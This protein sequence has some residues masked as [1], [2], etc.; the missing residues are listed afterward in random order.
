M[1]GKSTAKEVDL[2]PLQ[3]GAEMMMKA[4]GA[5]LKLALFEPER[6]VW[7]FP[8]I[9]KE[10]M[11]PITKEFVISVSKMIAGVGQD[12]SIPDQLGVTFQLNGP[13]LDLYSTDSKTISWI[14]LPN[15]KAYE[16]EHAVLPT[17]F[18]NQLVKLCKNGGH[19]IVQDDCAIVESPSGVRL[20]ARLVDVPRPVPF[21][22][23]ISRTIDKK[24]KS[25]AVPVPSRLKLALERASVLLET[26]TGTPI[27]LSFTPEFLRIN[28]STPYGSIK[29]SIKLD[30]PHV[31]IEGNLE[32]NLM[33]RALPFA[34]DLVFTEE[35]LIFFGPDA[36]VNLISRFEQ[37]N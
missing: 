2:A 26:H 10:N 3:E 4:G 11:I 17:A 19:F 12:V 8:D 16:V 1:L 28:A 29:D 21:A 37:N 22:D 30:K 34:T 25:K 14:R 6:S 20:F 35:A 23:V 5:K 36:Y 13:H 33:K 9:Q 15:F 24:L 7:Q 31:E 27:S 18:C 32:H